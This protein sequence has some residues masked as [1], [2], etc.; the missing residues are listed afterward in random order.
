MYKP[1]EQNKLLWIKPTYMW[2]T[3]FQKS[4]KNNEQMVVAHINGVLKTG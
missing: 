3:D 2:S 4:D 1:K